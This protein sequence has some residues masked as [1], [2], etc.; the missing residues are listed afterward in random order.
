MESDPILDLLPDNNYAECFNNSD[1]P[2]NTCIVNPMCSEICDD[3]VEY[4][5]NRRET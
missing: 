4:C 2:C 5:Y 1:S 3:F